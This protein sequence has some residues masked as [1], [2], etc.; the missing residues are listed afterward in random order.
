MNREKIIEK[1]SN[2]KMIV[3]DNAP[4]NYREIDVPRGTIIVLGYDE[5]KSAVSSGDKAYAI[6]GAYNG[7]EMK[8]SVSLLDFLE[9]CQINAKGIEISSKLNF[10]CETEME[11]AMWWRVPTDEEMDF[12]NMVYAKNVICKDINKIISE[13]EG[14]G[15]TEEDIIEYLED[16]KSSIVKM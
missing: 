4:R 5:R 3:L 8:Y 9:L 11:T 12:Y 7:G 10:G 16:L 6:M 14:G 1:W 13:I 15:M 2:V